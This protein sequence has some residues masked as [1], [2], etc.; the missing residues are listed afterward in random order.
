MVV[1]AAEQEVD[2]QD[3]DCSAGDDHDAVA[4]EEESEHIVHF[5]EPHIVHDEVELDK[6]GAKR[7]NA[8]E[9]HRGNR[10]QVGGRWW[11]LARDLIDANGRLDRLR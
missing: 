8:D 3:R 2:Q 1:L 10:A 6:D 7:E 9:Q 5:A 11:D 4:K